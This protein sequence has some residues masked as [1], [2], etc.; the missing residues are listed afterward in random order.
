MEILL[1]L[2]FRQQIFNQTLIIHLN[3]ANLANEPLN[4][5]NISIEETSYMAVPNDGAFLK[6]SCLQFKLFTR[7]VI[8][9]HPISDQKIGKKTKGKKFDKS[10][11][12][13][14]QMHPTFRKDFRI[15]KLNKTNLKA[16]H[17]NFF[18]E[19]KPTFFFGLILLL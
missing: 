6:L 9:D 8:D 17:G 14:D 12:I 10:Q 16:A 19:I 15:K 18:S 11:I 4:N 1:F 5:E 3:L 13:S 7:D 2:Y